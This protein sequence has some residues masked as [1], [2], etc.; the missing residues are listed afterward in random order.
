VNPDLQ[1]LEAAVGAAVAGVGVACAL[2]Y[3]V[4]GELRA[5][6]LVALLTGFAPPPVPVQVVYAAG[7]TAAAKVR[8]FVELATGGLRR[9][10]ATI[11]A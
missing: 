4:D 9:R 6:T 7:S 11:G 2:S 8:A 1:A 10:L 5:G 3:Q